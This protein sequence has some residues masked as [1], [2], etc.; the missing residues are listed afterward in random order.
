MFALLLGTRPEIIKMSPVIRACERRDLDFFVLHTGQHYSYEMDRVFFEDLRLPEPAY[1]LDT[2][3]GSHAEQTGKILKGVE[4]VLAREKPD[5]ILVQGDTNTVLAGALAA[6]K[7]YVRRD[8]QGKGLLPVK[9]G[10][11]EA[12]LRSFDRTMPEEVNR[13]VADHLADAC[14]A[15]TEE[16]RGNLLR[17][18]IPGEKVFVTGNTIVDAVRENLALAGKA[19][20]VTGDLDLAE[21]GYFL[22]TLHRQEN[23]DS[24]ARLAGILGALERLHESTGIPIVFPMHPR[25]EKMVRAFGLPVGAFRI[26]RP[27]G[28]LSFLQLE[29]RAR[30]VLTDSGGVQEEACILGVPCVTLRDSTERPETV[31]AGANIVAGISPPAIL[32][33]VETMLRRPVTWENPFGDGRAGDRIMGILTGAGESGV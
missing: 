26:I 11:V 8:P 13:I 33:A 16:A 7:C 14:F 4:E 30:L 6:A 1:H 29:S 3:P 28:F 19:G 2:G 9:I 21:K 17:E 22:L 31:T 25:T 15:P 5:T 12:G 32:G 27:L 23:V 20:D 18:G 10:H 24:E